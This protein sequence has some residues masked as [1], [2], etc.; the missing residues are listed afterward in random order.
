MRI[1]ILGATSEIARDLTNLFIAQQ[2]HNLLLFAR[3]EKFINIST[4]QGQIA[5]FYKDFFVKGPFDAII[6][7]IGAGDPHKVRT[8]GKDILSI[9]STFDDLALGYLALNPKCKYINFSSGAIYS[10]VLGLSSTQKSMPLNI[11]S[12]S[13]FTDWYAISKLDAETKH[14]QNSNFFIVDIRI[15]NYFSHTQNLNSSFLITEILRSIRDNKI[16]IAS[17]ENIHRDYLNQA[18]LFQLL[19]IILEHSHLNQGIDAYSQAPISKT[20]LLSEMAARYGLKYKYL[21]HSNNPILHYKTIYH[22]TNKLANKLGYEPNYSSLT[23]V[24]KEIDD[25]LLIN[26]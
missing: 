17:P 8:I 10:P 6:N 1:A 5:Y 26:S 9:T 7:F 24:C 22:S 13:K 11:T 4:K 12:D 21:P 18:D 14:R 20:V 25:Y 16:L 23:G 2:R 19:E 15:F 3:D